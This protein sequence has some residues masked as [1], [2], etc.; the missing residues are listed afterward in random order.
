MSATIIASNIAGPLPIA[1]TFQAPLDGPATFQFSGTA[2]STTANVLI[3]VQVLLDG[4]VIGTAQLY[5]NSTSE[6]KTLPTQVMDAVLQSG[7]HKIV[8]QALNANTITDGNDNFSLA[9]LM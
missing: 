6:H 5:S 8:F 3:G 9:L 1:V 7:Q 2:W 4:V